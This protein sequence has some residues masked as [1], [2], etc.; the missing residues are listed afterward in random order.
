MKCR[1]CGLPLSPME[2]NDGFLCV[3]CELRQLRH[4]VSGIKEKLIDMLEF[5]SSFEE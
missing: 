1:D 4:V 5:M 2:L 3:Q